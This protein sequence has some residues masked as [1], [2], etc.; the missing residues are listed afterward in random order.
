MGELS[1]DG[2]LGASTLWMS[3]VSRV[4]LSLGTMSK[5]R[6]HL[7]GT[8]L[9]MSGK[10]E[11]RALSLRKQMCMAYVKWKAFLYEEDKLNFVEL[12]KRWRKEEAR[13]G[14]KRTIVE[15]RA[16]Q[17]FWKVAKHKKLAPSREGARDYAQKQFEEGVGIH[18]PEN[19]ALNSERGREGRRIQTETLTSPNIKE[20]VITTPEGV[21]FRV[22]GMN[23]WCEA[24]GVDKRNLH[25]TALLPNR[26]AKGY[27]LRRFDP[28][29]DAGIPWEN[30]VRETDQR[31]D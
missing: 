16:R 23:R 4:T 28:D 5:N 19:R 15:K 26:T 3:C 30:E 27:K 12:A 10:L 11:G 24:N 18:S 6:R 7:A 20:W 14:T 8:Y 31:E 21:E 9:Y 13:V 1:G 17:H 25:K 22:R 29:L 2:Y